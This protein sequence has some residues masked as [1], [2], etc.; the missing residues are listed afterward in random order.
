MA[1]TVRMSR[2]STEPRKTLICRI[3]VFWEDEA[4][5]STRQVGLLENRSLSGVSICVPEPMAIGT[6]VNV[7]GKL[8]E[9]AGIVL[10]C[11]PKGSEYLVDIQLD[12]RDLGWA[13]FGAGL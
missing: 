9:L 3:S 7:R 1:D 12:E 8:R 11:R 5:F 13:A 10:Y 2:P 4:G 6:K